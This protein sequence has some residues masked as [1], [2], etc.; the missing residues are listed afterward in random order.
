MYLDHTF[1]LRL[2][3]SEITPPIGLSRYLDQTFARRTGSAKVKSNSEVAQCTV[4]IIHKLT[5][6][7]QNKSQ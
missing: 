6:I 4:P 1:G 3:L 5:R 2:S 7:K